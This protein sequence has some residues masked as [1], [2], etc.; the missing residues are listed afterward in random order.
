MV[1][2]QTVQ[3]LQLAEVHSDTEKRKWALFDALIKRRWG[4]PMSTPNKDDADMTTDT[5]DNEIDD[6]DEMT[7]RHID[8][9]DSVDSQGTLMNQLPAYD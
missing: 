1:P 2:R 3:A 4:S 8:I 9:E 5:E 6:D 7:K